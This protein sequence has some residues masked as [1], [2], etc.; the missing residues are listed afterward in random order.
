M[1]LAM[2]LSLSGTAFAVLDFSFYGR[3][4]I[5]ATCFVNN[6]KHS[7]KS[8][9][10][11]LNNIAV[12]LDR[13]LKT[14]PITHVVREKGFSKFAKA[15]QAIF[16]VVGISDLTLYRNGVEKDIEEIP[17]TTVKKTIAGHG[18]AEKSEVAEGVRQYLI[19]EQKDIVFKT[20]DES[21]AVAVGVTYALQNKLIK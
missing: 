14:Y 6:K 11:R 13:I 8:H 17:P 15:T 4:K 21:D 5:V 20:D 1:I 16:K 18:G 9:A 12:E 7:K 2:D 10:Y 3:V 19:D